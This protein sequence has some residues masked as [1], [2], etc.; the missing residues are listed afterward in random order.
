MVGE[1]A[2]FENKGKSTVDNL[3]IR[4]R[5]VNVVS[6]GNGLFDLLDNCFDWEVR[7][8]ITGHGCVVLFNIC[9]GDLCIG[10]A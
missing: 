7:V 8:I 10:G 6:V 3:N 5:S 2:C 4:K 9:G 1:D